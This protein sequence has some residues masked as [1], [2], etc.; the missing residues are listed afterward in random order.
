M[1][2]GGTGDVLAGLCA[3]LFSTAPTP[4]SAAYTASVLNKRAGEVLSNIYGMHF[5]SED[6]AEELAFA[7]HLLKLD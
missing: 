5:C 7:A 6:L 4:L 1:T 3:A 2:K